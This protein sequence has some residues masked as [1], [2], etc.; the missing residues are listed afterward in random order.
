VV[1]QPAP[2]VTVTQ[3]QPNV[4]VN[5]GQPEIIVHQPAPQVTVMIPPPEITVR[6]PKPEVNVSQT[7]PQVSVN[8][9][10]PTVQVVPSQN[11]TVASVATGQPVVRFTS[12]QPQVN[13]SKSDQPVIHFEELQPGQQQ[14]AV[15][16]TTAARPGATATTQTQSAAQG[17]QIAVSELTGKTVMGPQPSDR[18][19][20]ISAVIM[21]TK[22][23][24]F[25]IVDKGGQ[26]YA[27]DV[28]NV[29]M[30]GRDLVLVGITDTARLPAWSDT[31]PANRNIKRLTA[32]QKVMIKTSG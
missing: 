26:K 30:R 10:K 21:D 29:Q 19:G 1:Q 31:D 6:M 9:E 2:Q 32:D 16:S 15:G 27:I 13:I 28:D 22:D 5:Q 24:P 4:S 14:A 23:K 7:Q 18:F 17:N 3:A 20:T 12:D 8:Q 25:V 11:Q